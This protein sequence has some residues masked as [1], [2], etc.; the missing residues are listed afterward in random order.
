MLL[1]L[2]NDTRPHFIGFFRSLVIAYFAFFAL[3]LSLRSHPI[4]SLL[5]TNSIQPTSTR[6]FLKHI[7]HT[8]RTTYCVGVAGHVL[9]ADGRLVC[10]WLLPRLA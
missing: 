1:H 6:A 10:R 7:L 4:P 9:E 3:H 2:F 5:R 8:N